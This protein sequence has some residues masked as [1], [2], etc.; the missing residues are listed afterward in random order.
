MFAID[1]EYL[2]GAIYRGFHANKLRFDGENHTLKIGTGFIWL[3][4]KDYQIIN[5]VKSFSIVQENY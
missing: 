5:N 2:D 4:E 1:I 3:E